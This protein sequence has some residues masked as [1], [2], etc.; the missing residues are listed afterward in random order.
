MLRSYSHSGTKP[1]QTNLKCFFFLKI[2]VKLNLGCLPF[3]LRN[4]IFQLE[5]RMVCILVHLESFR[6]Y[7]VLVGLI[8]MGRGG[9]GPHTLYLSDRP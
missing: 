6:N 3:T 1:K 9:E 2:G 8:D 4:Q 7:E 5:N